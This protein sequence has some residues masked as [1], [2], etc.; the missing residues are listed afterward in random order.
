MVLKPD[1]PAS[2]DRKIWNRI[3][4]A[5]PDDYEIP[6]RA[7]AE[8]LKP[9]QIAS[10]Q[11]AKICFAIVAH[12]NEDVLQDQVTN[13]RFYNPN[14]S[15]VLYNGGPD[16]DFGKGVDIDICPYSRP[17]N[18]S[19]KLGRFLPDVM[20]WL[21]E[22]GGDYEYLINLDSDY[23]FLNHG[24]E[25]WLEHT[26]HGY[27]MMGMYLKLYR[28]RQ[29]SEGWLPGET[30]WAEWDRWQPF[31]GTD[32]FCG[33]LNGMQVYRRGLIRDML[34]GFDWEQLEERLATTNVYALE[35]ILCS[36]LAVRCGGRVRPYPIDP[37]RYVRLGQPYTVED[38]TTAR[39]L[40]DLFFIHPI[41]R[42][43]S[44][45][46]RQYIQRLSQ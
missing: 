19:Y 34:A 26:M 2:A 21:E 31:F 9:K 39:E 11:E 40:T 8:L 7:F 1:L 46:A 32:S 12:A 17:L 15:V 37:I 45:P 25:T 28:T 41:E 5:V 44:D 43:M 18:A 16:P 42:E 3:L 10:G 14:A 23:L 30:L 33:S 36:T 20:R 22:T 6:D 35:E 24:F 4:Q 38:V 27:D 13:L 29:D